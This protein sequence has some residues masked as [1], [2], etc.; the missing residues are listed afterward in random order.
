MPAN[1]TGSRRA[2]R[3][4]LRSARSRPHQLTISQPVV[5]LRAGAVLPSAAPERRRERRLLLAAAVHP[6]RRVPPA[7]RLVTDLTVMPA[8]AAR[9]EPREPV[10]MPEEQGRPALGLLGEL[11][12]LAA[13]ARGPEAGVPFGHL[14]QGD[15]AD[16][17]AVSL[18]AAVSDRTLT[19]ALP[20]HP[21]PQPAQIPAR[22]S[23]PR[24]AG[25]P[26]C[27]PPSAK[28]RPGRRAS[29]TRSPRRSGP[30][31]LSPG[32]CPGPCGA[33]PSGRSGP[34]PR[35]RGQAAEA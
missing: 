4:G 1:R 23:S 2:G 30:G 33:G 26:A 16:L 32:E 20:R 11:E 10:V 25:P 17:H 31:P 14:F 6:A 19:T 5:P 28:A 35:I 34:G 12:V 18:V 9:T 21:Q 8:A 29:Q 13:F 15:D 24:K 7:H 27:S 22:S 3:D